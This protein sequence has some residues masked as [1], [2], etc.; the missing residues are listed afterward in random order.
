MDLYSIS[1]F[2]HVSEFPPLFKAE[3]FFL[4]S[5]YQKMFQVYLAM[6]IN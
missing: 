3:D 4:F 2:E 5:F 1:F 6:L